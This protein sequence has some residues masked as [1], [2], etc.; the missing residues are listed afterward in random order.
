MN[1]NAVYYEDFGAIGDGVADD[2]YAVRRAHEYAN[3]RG[4]SVHGKRGAS[5]RF[6]KGSGS[7]TIPIMTSTYWHGARIIFDDS[8]MQ[9]GMPE[10]DTPIFTITSREPIIKYTADKCPISSIEKGAQNIGFAPGYRAM[11]VLYDEN[12]RQYIRNAGIISDNGTAQHEFV[13][14]DKDGNIDKNTPLQWTYKNITAMNIVNVE[15]EPIEILGDDGDKKGIV[16]TISNHSETDNRYLSRVIRIARSNVKIKNIHHL[17]TNEEISDQGAPYAGFTQINSAENVTFENMTLQRYKV[18]NTYYRSYEIRGTLANNVVWRNCNMSNFF[19]PDGYTI[20]Q[21]MMG[22]NYCKNLTLDGVEFNTFDCHHGC[23]NVTIRNSR[24]VYVSAIGEGTLLVEN[25]EFYIC[26]HCIV[27]W[28]RSDYG[29]TWYGDLIMKNI[30]VK[31]S[32]RNNYIALVNAYWADHYFGYPAK[33]PSNIYLDGLKVIKYEASVN[34]FGERSERI[35]GESLTP[36]NFFL[37]DIASYTDRDISRH[38][39]EG[40]GAEH[41]PYKAPDNLYI[42]NIADI[43]LLFPNT[44]MFR[45]MKI[46]KK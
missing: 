9:Y 15:D 27:I 44:P 2:F 32:D 31:H 20:H 40:G 19:A 25:C 8:E 29:A 45:D 17:I 22:T 4:L 34:D 5:Y 21:G 11:V 38:I 13:M 28:L 16:E 43:E 33:L 10:Y 24:L 14:V 23:Y 1:E 35:L 26:N 37:P 7:D 3:E 30:T 36:V 42:S 18:F 12:V 39:S 46:H 6:G 41:N